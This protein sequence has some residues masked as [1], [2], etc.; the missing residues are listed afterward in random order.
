MPF[1]IIAY[2]WSFAFECTAVAPVK[3]CILYSSNADCLCQA[4]SQLYPALDIMHSSTCA[5]L[6]RLARRHGFKA[7]SY[8]CPDVT[9]RGR[10]QPPGPLAVL[11]PLLAKVLMKCVF[12]IGD[13][14]RLQAWAR[15]SSAVIVSYL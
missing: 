8:V 1:H 14:G 7:L 11:L 6:Q 12:L 9:T 13:P 5:A 2:E 10:K 15:L 4:G 3:M